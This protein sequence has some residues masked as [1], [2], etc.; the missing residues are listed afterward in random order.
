[1]WI[2]GMVFDADKAILFMMLIGM[3][4]FIVGLFIGAIT[5]RQAMVDRF[6]DIMRAKDMIKWNTLSKAWHWKDNDQKVGF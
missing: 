6:Y 4:T 5:K 3:I 2:L 1:M